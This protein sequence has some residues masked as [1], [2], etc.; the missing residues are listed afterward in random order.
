VT[1]TVNMTRWNKA[2]QYRYVC[3][4]PCGELRIVAVIK[5]RGKP[6]IRL[7]ETCYADGFW[8]S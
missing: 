7:C 5:R 3:E 8:R 6:P 2:V 4:G 1:A